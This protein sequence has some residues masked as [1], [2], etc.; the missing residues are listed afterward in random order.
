MGD[1]TKNQYIGVG[2]LKR[3]ALAVYRFKVGAWEK[4]WGGGVFEGGGLYPNAHYG[5]FVFIFIIFVFRLFHA[6]ESLYVF[7]LTGPNL[8]N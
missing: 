1:F 6:N 7:A 8:E 3:G 2:Y 4:R 5:K